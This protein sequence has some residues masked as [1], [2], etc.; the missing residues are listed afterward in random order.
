VIQS[1]STINGCDSIIATTTNLL[2]SDEVTIN[3][4]SCNPIDTGWVTQSLINQNGC[5]SIVAVYTSLIND[6]SPIQNPVG[7]TTICYDGELILDVSNYDGSEYHWNSGAEGAVITIY[8]QGI[9]IVDFIQSNGCI[10][11]DTIMVQQIFCE[12][13]CEVVVPKAFTPNGDGD[14]DEFYA[15]TNCEEEITYFSFRIY[16]R[17]GEQVFETD[18]FNE[19]WDGVFK[20]QPSELDNYL[21]YFEY[22]L[23]GHNSIEKGKGVVT[24]IR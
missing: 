12:E 20:G 7:D 22:Q 24:L 11:Q 23:A 4:T 1:F 21:Y 16:N 15:L 17:W 19:G 18:D 6:S 13:P 9:Y 3:T 5:D 8:S 14:N 2:V 10:G